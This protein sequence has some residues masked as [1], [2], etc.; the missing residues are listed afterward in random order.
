MIGGWMNDG[1]VPE[2]NPDMAP[3]RLRRVRPGPPGKRRMA[4]G[5]LQAPPAPLASCEEGASWAPWPPR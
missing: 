3:V 1:S 2:T 5:V 4:P